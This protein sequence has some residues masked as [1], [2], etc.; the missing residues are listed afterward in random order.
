MSN[1]IVDTD[2]LGNEIVDESVAEPVEEEVVEAKTEAEETPKSRFDDWDKDT[3]IKN[4]QELEKLQSRHAQELGTLRKEV[5]SFKSQTSHQQPEDIDVDS[6]LDNPQEAVNKSISNNP[7]VKELRETLS[8]LQQTE[9]LTQIRNEHPDFINVANSPE[10]QNWVM[11]SPIRQD[12]HYRANNYDVAAA[13]E[14]LGTFKERQKYTKTEAAKEVVE[15]KRKEDL[16]AASSEGA[17][18]GGTS[19]K[20]FKKHDLVR[21]NMTDPEKYDAMLPEIMQAYTEGRVR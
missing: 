10:Y 11:D 15:S 2:E 8:R 19:A 6:L 7:E 12:L 21:L 1:I 13:M 14:L 3:A 17:S 5:E 16:A 9:A 4:Y 20:I 18:S